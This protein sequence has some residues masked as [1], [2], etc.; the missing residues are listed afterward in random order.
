MYI[1]PI[2]T[3]THSHCTAHEAE[4]KCS[5]PLLELKAWLYSRLCKRQH[6]DRLPL[7]LPKS[8]FQATSRLDE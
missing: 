8:I 3:L 7:L 2:H 5:G 6:V 1:P 4:P